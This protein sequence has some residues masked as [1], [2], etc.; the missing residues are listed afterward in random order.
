MA[1]RVLYKGRKGKDVEELQYNLKKLGY[2][3][4]AQINTGPGTFGPRTDAAVRKFQK[5]NGLVVDGK[6]GPLTRAKLA[7]KLNPKPATTNPPVKQEPAKPTPPLAEVPSPPPALPAKTVNHNLYPRL[8]SACVVNLVTNTTIYFPTP[9]EDITDSISITNDEETVRGR[10][11]PYIGY[12]S[13]SSR[14]ISFSLDLHDDYCPSGVV[15]TVNALKALE[16]PR[17]STFTIPPHCYL[18]LGNGIRCT[19]IC[20]S[21]DVTWKGPIRSNT[22]TMA[23]VSLQFNSVVSVPFS[24]ENVEVNGNDN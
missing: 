1:T 7:E 13:T 5:D 17:Y 2:M 24:S 19:C 18:N 12:N 21:V 20:T 16:Y 14:Q 23:N 10:S 4:Q 6:V 11:A 9:P 3:T 15:K 8:S 22:Y